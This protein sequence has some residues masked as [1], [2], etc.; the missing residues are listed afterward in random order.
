MNKHVPQSWYWSEV[1]ARIRR[2]E[3]YALGGFMNPKL[4]RKGTRSGWT[5]W[6]QA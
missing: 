4:H 3:F 2:G 6:K 1:Y 5:Y